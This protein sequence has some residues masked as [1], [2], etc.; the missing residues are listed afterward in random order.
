M[1]LLIRPPMKRKSPPKASPKK[2]D[3]SST[4]S[5]TTTPNGEMN[6]TPSPDTDGDV[7]EVV[8]PP[9][10]IPAVVQQTGIDSE[11]NTSP[12][13]DD[14]VDALQDPE[15]TV[16]AKSED[17]DKTPEPIPAEQLGKTYVCIHCKIVK[18]DV[19]LVAGCK[20]KNK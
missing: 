8:D 9:L 12:T 4:D 10:P 3:D 6:T 13:T 19:L 5:T 17:D 2:E 14:Y 11:G 20:K 15:G 16:V 1:F 7:A 18:E